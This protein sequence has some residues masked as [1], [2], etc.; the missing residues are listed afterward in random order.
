MQIRAAVAK[1]AARRN[2]GVVEVILEMGLMTKDELDK[3]LQPENLTRPNHA[4]HSKRKTV[5]KK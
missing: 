2:S 5:K 3:I 4:G 1:E